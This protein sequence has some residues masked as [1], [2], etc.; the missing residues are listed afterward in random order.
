MK[1]IVNVN[2]GGNHGH[3]LRNYI[4]T[5]IISQLFNNVKY[6]HI[7]DGVTDSYGIG[8]NEEFWDFQYLQNSVPYLLGNWSEPNTTPNWKG[9]VRMM[10]IA[11]LLKEDGKDYIF[12]ARNYVFFPH[13][14]K[15]LIDNN[16]IP[17]RDYNLFFNE[18][19]KKLTEK[20]N[21]TNI[22]THTTPVYNKD[23]I[24][25]AVH[26]NRGSDVCSPTSMRATNSDLERFQFKLEYFDKIIQQITD[27]LNT[28][29]KKFMFY[30]YTEAL[31]SEEIVTYFLNRENIQVCIGC[32]RG[33]RELRDLNLIERIFHSFVQCDILVTCNSSFSMTSTFL[34]YKKPFIFKE[35]TPFRTMPYDW[36]L[37]TDEQGVFDVDKLEGYII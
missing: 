24:N 6:L 14:V 33:T 17:F 15:Y 2:C 13:T 1:Y 7:N 23:I 11:E 9:E 3:K 19:S 12:V 5:Y 20:Y 25:I 35:H 29:N 8:F 32:N 22:H 10:D 26:I 36:A 27:F 16:I 4:S 34:R 21:H 18:L 30:I 31:N 28:K 37:T